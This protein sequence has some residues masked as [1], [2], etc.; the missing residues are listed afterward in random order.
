M[1]LLH[2]L[3][4]V[5]LF[6]FP[7]NQDSS[8]KL[9]YEGI[10]TSTGY[11]VREDGTVMVGNSSLSFYVKIYEQNLIQTTSVIGQPRPVDFEYKFKGIDKDGNR[12]YE[13]NI[14]T[15]MLVDANYDI[16]TVISLPSSRYGNNVQEHTY[17]EV[18]KGDREAEFN[19][20]HKEDGSSYETQYQLYQLPEYYLMNED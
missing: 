13:L 20:K 15:S 5:L 3:L 8:N 1:K 6:T 7:W 17:W 12:V 10:Y 16:K 2:I 9:L 14:V 11:G 19:Q 18:V 4:F